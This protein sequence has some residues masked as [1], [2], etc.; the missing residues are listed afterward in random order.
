MG[1]R[2]TAEDRVPERD[3]LP[4]PKYIEAY[5]SYLFSVRGMSERTLKAYRND[6]AYYSVYCANFGFVPIKAGPPEIRA[7]LS[8]LSAGEMASASVNRILSSIRGLYRWLALTGMR[9]DNPST[10]LHNLKT[11]RSLPIFLW[12]AEMADFAGLPELSG[13]LWPPRDKAIIM[14]MYSAGLRISEAASLNITDLDQDLA[15]GRI[16]GK[17]NKERQVFFT[18]EGREA[19]AAW[20]PYRNSTI[21]AEHPTSKL[22]ISQKGSPLSISG[23]RYIVGKYAERSALPKNVHPHALRHSFA[24][25][26]VNSGCDVRVVQE[27]LGHVS[28]STTQRY[29]HVNIEGLKRVYSQAHPHGG[30]VSRGKK[31]EAVQ[32]PLKGR[33]SETAKQRKTK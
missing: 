14:V 25:H 31:R 1:N 11:S 15:G 7:F 12:E 5:L 21:T 9:K 3:T 17:G 33:L 19:L 29:T 6:L 23:L 4:L 26:L 20:L 22:F 18:E 30:G 2:K 8:E 10:T 28:L 16:I 13:I 24:T 32:G 27:L